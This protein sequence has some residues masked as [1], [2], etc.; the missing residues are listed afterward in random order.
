MPKSS[1]VLAKSE[2]QPDLGTWFTS[3]RYSRFFKESF[4]AVNNRIQNVNIF[5]IKEE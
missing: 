4:F 3:F 5:S 2:I 1:T